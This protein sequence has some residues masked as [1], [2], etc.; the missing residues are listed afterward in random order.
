MGYTVKKLTLNGSDWSLIYVKNSTLQHDGITAD[1][2]ILR[3]RGYQEIPAT[4]PGNLEIDLENSGI[5]ED[6]FW[7]DNHRNRSCEYLH[8]FYTKSFNYDG[9]LTDPTLLFD[10]I[11]TVSSI[12]LNGKLIGTS[13]NMLISHEFQ[14]AGALVVGTNVITV[15]IKPAVIEARKYKSTL[16][17]HA[18]KYNNESLYMR[19]APHMYSWDIMPRLVSAGIW[20]S[21]ALK[22]NKADRIDEFYCYTTTCDPKSSTALLYFSCNTTVSKDECTDYEIEIKGVCKDSTFAYRSKLWHT[23]YNDAISV[24]GAKLWWP[25]F[26]GEQNLYDLTVTLYYNGT[27][28]DVHSTRIGIRTVELDRT[29]TTDANGNGEFCFKVNGKRIFCMGTNWVPV[30]A[31]HSRDAKRLPSIM[32][33]LTDINCN[34]IRIWGGNV[35]EDDLLYDFCDENG[36]MIWQDFIMGC[37]VYPQDEVFQNRLYEEAV[38]VIKR[39]RHHPA[40]ILWA[41]DNEND[42]VYKC[43]WGGQS[44][45]DPNENV[46]TRKVIKD[47]IRLHDYTRP[48]LPSSPYID[49]EA[50]ESNKNISEDHLWGPRDY[51]KGNYYKNTVCHFASETGYHG[52]NAPKSVEKFIPKDHIWTSTS[53]DNWSGID[54]HYWL[55]HA[56]ALEDEKT[57]PFTY[58]IRLMADQVT[59]LFGKSVPNTL[60]D[61][62]KASQIS[63]AEAKKYFIERFRLSKWRRTGIIWWN[64]IDG[65]PQFSDAVVDYYGIKKLAY[66]YIKRSQQPLCIMFDEPKGDTVSVYAVNEFSEDKT[67]DYEITDLTTGKTVVKSTALAEGDSSVC[68]FKFDIEQ[69]EKHFYLIKW[70]V[71]GVE[72]SNHYMTNLIDIDYEQYLKYISKCAYDRFEGFYE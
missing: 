29:S 7:G 19:K 50:Y 70:T 38:F 45:R 26:N 30:D 53:S 72:Y 55:A 60:S 66:S 41:G 35:Y 8:C 18:F 57:A 68:V 42:M 36:V 12:Y 6:P 67:V 23:S 13:E 65:W 56:A 34:I 22:E 47:A 43:A 2:D 17:D 71:D 20:R 69:S 58:R 15:H 33:M 51:F 25:R 11:D 32:P 5:I 59:T 21:V 37:A 10:G 9:S 1:I 46:L 61:F 49:Q 48:Y 64:L 28:V 54:N 27:P 16:S 62:A 52:C 31:L 4:V 39:L 3:A 44:P 24:S 40:I 14:V 63:Q